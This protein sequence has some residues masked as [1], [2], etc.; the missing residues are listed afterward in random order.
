MRIFLIVIVALLWF[1]T[2][3]HADAIWQ[4]VLFEGN[5]YWLIPATLLIEY[6]AVHHLLDGN[7]GKSVWVTIAMN[8]ASSFVGAV[9][10]IPFLTMSRYSHLNIFN[11]AFSFILCMF[12]ITVIVEGLIVFQSAKSKG[13]VKV[14]AL[15]GLVN[16]LTTGLIVFVLSKPIYKL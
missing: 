16:A 10:Q 5:N 3:A 2:T 6:P 4:S 9:V 12:V 15:I 1:Q 14:F 11:N 7:I 8:I 13:W